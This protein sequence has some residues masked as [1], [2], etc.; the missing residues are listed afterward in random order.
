MSE[1]G[2]HCVS[3]ISLE[4]QDANHEL[5]FQTIRHYCL[6]DTIPHGARYGK[7]CSLMD[8]RRNKAT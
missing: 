4:G 1:G 2:L 3:Y 8:C 7:C 6:F 5:T